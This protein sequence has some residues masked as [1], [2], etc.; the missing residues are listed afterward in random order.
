MFLKMHF[1]IQ[2]QPTPTPVQDHKEFGS[3]PQGHRTHIHRNLLQEDDQKRMQ[4]LKTRINWTEIISVQIRICN[5]KRHKV[6][7]LWLRQKN[8]KRFLKTLQG[9][10]ILTRRWEN[11]VSSCLLFWAE[12]EHRGTRGSHTKEG[13]PQ[14]SVPVA[15]ALWHQKYQSCFLQAPQRTPSIPWQAPQALW[16]YKG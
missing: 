16:Y 9:L 7:C 4:A 8:T 15:A 6:T 1:S 11:T 10:S 14:G 13:T 3:A 5:P 2:T 12:G